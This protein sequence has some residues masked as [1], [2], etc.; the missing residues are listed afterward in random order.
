MVGRQDRADQESRARA[1]SIRRGRSQRLADASRCRPWGGRAVSSGATRSL[2]SRIPPDGGRRG[3]RACRGRRAGRGSGCGINGGGRVHGISAL[4]KH[5]PHAGAFLAAQHRSPREQLDTGHHEQTHQKDQSGGP[6]QQ[7]QSRA[8]WGR[9]RSDCRGRANA[10]SSLLGRDYLSSVR[11]DHLGSR[12]VSGDHLG[13]VGGSAVGQPHPGHHNLACAVE[14]PFVRRGRHCRDHRAD[15]RPDDRAVGA[16]DRP[17][18]GARGSG[19]CSGNDLA[20]G[21]ACLRRGGGG[22]RGRRRRSTS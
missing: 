21:Q 6:D 16:E 8:R 3:R 13:D 19:A 2:R 17:G 11:V 22:R 18:D 12:R 5:P 4:A 20:D 9:H 7:R 10:R 1:G 15:S 14:R